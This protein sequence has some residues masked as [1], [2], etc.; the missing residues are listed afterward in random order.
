MANQ[1]RNGGNVAVPDENRPSWR[2]QDEQGQRNR[3]NMDEDDYDDDR[4]MARDRYWEDREDRMTERYGRGQSG[5]GAGRYGADRSYEVRNLGLRGYDERPRDRDAGTW[6]ERMERGGGMERVDYDRSAGDRYAGDRSFARGGYPS[7]YGDRGYAGGYGDRGYAGGHPGG[8]GDRGYPGG[9]GDRGYDR[10]GMYRT[11]RV[12]G[13]MYGR[14]EYSRGDD[15]MQRGMQSH[16][17]KGP[18]GYQR[19]DERIREIV[20]EVLSDDHDVDATHIEVAVKNGEVVLAGMVGDR[21]QKR[22]AEDVVERVS[23]VKDVQ[24]QLRVRDRGGD[25]AGKDSEPPTGMGTSDKRH[26]A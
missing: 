16:R 15:R 1:E 19:S 17:G 8:Y 10:G 24:N 4:F 23:G 11:P 25:G 18:S 22:I 12:R 3:R 2:P 26:R 14:S 6:G 7:G 20:C 5:Y 13:A 9:Y 21:W